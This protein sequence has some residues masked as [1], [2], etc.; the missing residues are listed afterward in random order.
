MNVW[1]L[2]AWFCSSLYSVRCGELVWTQDLLNRK[3]LIIFGIMLAYVLP[4]LSCKPLRSPRAV[5][6]WAL[7]ITPYISSTSKWYSITSFLDLTIICL[8]SLMSKRVKRFTRLYCKQ[9]FFSAAL[10]VLYH[11]DSSSYRIFVKILYWNNFA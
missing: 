7:S 5:D 6:M 3:R 10:L 2:L 11:Y 4:V 8:V 1:S 9:V